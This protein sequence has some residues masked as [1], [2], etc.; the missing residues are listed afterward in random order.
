MK[1]P[2]LIILSMLISISTYSQINNDIIG[3]FSSNSFTHLSRKLTLKAKDNGLTTTQKSNDLIIGSSD[4]NEIVSITGDYYLNGN[5]TIVNNG[6]LNI[7]S[8]NFK[9]GGDIFIMNEGQMNVR[10]GNFTVIQEFI[11]EHDAVVIQSGKMLFSGVHFQSNGQSWSN[12]FADSASYI[13]KN[14]EVS[15]GFITTAFLGESKGIINNTQMPGEFLCFGPNN[16]EI[17]NSDLLLMWLVLPDSSVVDFSL[18]NDSLVTNW[19]FS[20]NEPFVDNIPYSL[21]IDSCRN[22]MWGLISI[23]GSQARFSD[24]EFRTIG[25][26]FQNPDSIVVSNITN[27]SNHSDEIIN[28][29]DRELHLIDSQVHTWSF[30]ASSNSNITIENCVFGELLAQDSSKVL[31]NNSICDGTGGYIGAFHQSFLLITGS[32]IK[33]QVISRQNAVLVGAGSTFWGSEID[34]DESSVMFIANTSTAVEPKAFQSAVIFE[35][36]CPHL[37]GL[38]DEFVPVFGTARIIKGPE[39]PIQFYGYNVAYSPDFENPIWQQIDGFQSKA[40]LDDT[41]IT[42]D[43]QNLTTGNYAL[44]LSLHHSFGEPVSMVSSARLNINTNI[45]ENDESMMINYFLSQNFPNPFNTSTTIRFGLPNSLSVILKIF[46]MQGKEVV[47]LID[48]ELPAGEHQINF[49][50]KELPS[51]IYF[52]SLKTQNFSQMKKFIIVK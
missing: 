1:I 24:T 45:K 38:I 46:N 36:Q 21:K 20:S 43:T 31:I 7:D 18:P 35:A 6:I 30:Y 9:I 27:E 41:L 15:D 44:Q 33:S 28:V 47:T 50:P 37:E 8:A 34:A 26:M 19:N 3:H 25:L 52:Y 51:G 40:V 39:N 48:G 5:L 13:L 49:N 12:A 29:P 32:L 22:V 4:P 17:T 16:L 42:W 23:S 14:C 10:G 2:I 11:Y